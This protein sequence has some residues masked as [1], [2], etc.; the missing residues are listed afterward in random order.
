MNFILN[1][2]ILFSLSVYSK[3]E[4]T[5]DTAATDIVVR[6]KGKLL[7]KEFTLFVNTIFSLHR[8]KCVKPIFSFL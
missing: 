4:D 6:L 2:K 8:K 5:G 7:D 3:D 1:V